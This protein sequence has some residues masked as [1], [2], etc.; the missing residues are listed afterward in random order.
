MDLLRG[1]CDVV[2]VHREHV[3][4]AAHVHP[5]LVLIHVQDA[6]VHGLVRQRVVLQRGATLQLCRSRIFKQKYKT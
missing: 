3:V 5:V 1:M 4:L 2:D 6:V